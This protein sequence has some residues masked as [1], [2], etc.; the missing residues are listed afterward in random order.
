M[1][2]DRMQGNGLMLDE[3]KLRWNSRKKFFTEKGAQVPQETGQGPKPVGA[4]E[5]FGHFSW[6]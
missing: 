2:S 4:Q 3:G 6:I 1:S 5:M